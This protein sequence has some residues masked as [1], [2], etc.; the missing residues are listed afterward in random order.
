MGDPGL[1]PGTSSLSVEH[2]VRRLTALG[3]ERPERVGL[4]NAADRA[5]L[6]PAVGGG[7]Q[8]VSS[9]H[10]IVIVGRL[11]LESID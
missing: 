5:R 11:D 1:A 9:M 10:R 7:F 2:R 6:H 8:D 4:R 3:R